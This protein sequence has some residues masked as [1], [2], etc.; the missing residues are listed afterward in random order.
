MSGPPNYLAAREWHDFLERYVPGEE[1]QARD[2]GPEYDAYS[3]YTQEMAD[4]IREIAE[5]Y[6]LEL[7]GERLCAEDDQEEIFLSALG[8]PGLWQDGAPVSYGFGYFYECGNFSAELDVSLGDISV[9]VTYRYNGKAYL[10]TALSG[11]SR[12]TCQEWIELLPSGQQVLVAMDGEFVRV[13]CDREDVFLSMQFFC[14]NYDENGH[15]NTLT[16]EDIQQVVSCLDWSIVTK[17]PDMTQAKQRLEETQGAE[18]TH[19]NPFANDY[20]SYDDV[21]RKL[22]ENGAEI[23]YALADITGDGVPELLLGTGTS[24]GTVKTMVDGKAETLLSNGMDRGLELCQGNILRTNA[25]GITYFI[26]WEEK[27]GTFQTFLEVGYDPWEKNWYRTE[28]GISEDISQEEYNSLL[29][30]Y[31]VL[32]IGMMPLG[33]YPLP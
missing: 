12:E 7:T 14:Q 13:F 1:Q 16:R 3:V 8:L 32:D 5:K 28:N 4:K 23:S 9:P 26:K 30:K 11:I 15:L 25:G 24:F 17:K 20:H 29:E 18:S 10:D 31:P 27:N 6:N 19:E 2:F 21:I 33:S 22:L